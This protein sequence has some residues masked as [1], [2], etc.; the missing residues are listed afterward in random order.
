MKEWAK[1]ENTKNITVARIKSYLNAPI[2]DSF[3]T[4]KEE[5]VKFPV[6]WY[7]DGK[8]WLDQPITINNKLINFITSLTLNG[9]PAPI[10][11]KNPTLLEKFIGST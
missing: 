6:S 1:S 8:I 7:H 10:G 11:S 5:A 3:R 2:I 4:L 9:E